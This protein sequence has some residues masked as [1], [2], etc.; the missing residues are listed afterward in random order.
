MVNAES[1]TT[2]TWVE[3]DTSAPLQ[4]FDVRIAGTCENLS[5]D[6]EPPGWDG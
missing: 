6:D 4:F 5:L 1:K 3:T 2:L